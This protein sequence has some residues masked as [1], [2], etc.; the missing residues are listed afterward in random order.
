MYFLVVTVHEP[1]AQQRH[2]SLIV[3]MLTTTLTVMMINDDRRSLVA[4]LYVGFNH[5]FPGSER[6]FVRYVVPSCRT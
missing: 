1:N 6:R 2:C 5:S 4:H 3:M